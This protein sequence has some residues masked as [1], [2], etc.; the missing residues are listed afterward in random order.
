V[1]KNG[2]SPNKDTMFEIG[3]ITKAF[4]A[5]LLADMVERG[6]VAMDDPVSK[7]LPET[8]KVPA[9]NGRQI[10]LADNDAHLRAPAVVVQH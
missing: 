8:V 6:E 5:L 9:R 2:L 4:T 3:S 1:A 10:T 7:Y